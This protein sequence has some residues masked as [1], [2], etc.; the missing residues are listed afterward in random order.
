MQQ[1]YEIV[2][3]FKSLVISFFRLDNHKN[4][5]H[6]F[7]GAIIFGTGG[8]SHS[9]FCSVLILCILITFNIIINDDARAMTK[10]TDIS[11]LTLYLHESA[12]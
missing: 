12:F 3:F 4:F 5:K 9:S 6:K 8:I 11:I 7:K 1:F 10:S 2:R